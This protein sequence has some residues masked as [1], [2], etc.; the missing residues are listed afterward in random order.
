MHRERQELDIYMTHRAQLVSYAN[1][2]VYDVGYAE[3]VVQEAWARLNRA[4]HAQPIDEPVRYLYRIV[5]NLS[6]DLLRRLSREGYRTSMD[7]EIASQI[8]AD[9]NPSAETILIARE[10][11]RIVLDAIAELPER[12]RIAIEMYRFGDFKLRE[13]AEHLEI[14]V[15]LAHR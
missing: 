9:D 1:R 4:S 2:I 11:I 10:D 13:I 6:I 14:S 5:R 7:I 12:E 3:D 15:G 8:I